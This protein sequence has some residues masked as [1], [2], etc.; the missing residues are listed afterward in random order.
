MIEQADFK[1]HTIL[2]SPDAAG[3]YADF[4]WSNAS[5]GNYV[6]IAIASVFIGVSL[7]ACAAA[8]IERRTALWWLW[9]AGS[10]VGVSKAL[11][12]WTTGKSD[13]SRLAPRFRSRRF[14]G[15]GTETGTPLALS[16]LSQSS[17]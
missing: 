14:T 15:R 10:L 7:F 11:I 17:I 2:T 13:F 4:P 3:S 9:A 1:W 8:V 5:V 12:D 16:P 6:F